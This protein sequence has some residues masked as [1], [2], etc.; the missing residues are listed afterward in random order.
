MEPTAQDVAAAVAKEAGDELDGAV[1]KIEHCMKQL[2]EEQVWWRPAASMNSI[3]NLILHVCGNVRQWIT[4]GIGGAEDAR[5]RPTEFSE[6]DSI[7]RDELLRRLDVAVAEAKA[8]LANASPAVLL[9]SRRIQGF[10]VTGMQAI[11]ESI[12][13]FRGHTQE[14]VHMTRIRLGGDYEFAFVPTTPEQ[15]A[16]Q[17]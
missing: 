1:R 8:A 14:I 7:A 9:G 17:E 11:F 5:N 2:N 16:P 4:S 12:A 6:Q 13:H 15:G 3:A 10:D